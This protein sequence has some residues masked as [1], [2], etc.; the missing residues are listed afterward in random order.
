MSK[1]P[2]KLTKRVN[3][4]GENLHILLSDSMSFNDFFRKNVTAT[5]IQELQADGSFDNHFD[6]S[7]K[8][9]CFHSHGDYLTLLMNL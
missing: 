3:T 8:V 6:G 2:K 5:K 7:F 4:E 1:N 9:K